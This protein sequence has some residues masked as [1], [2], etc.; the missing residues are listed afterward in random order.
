MGEAI[1]FLATVSKVQMLSDGGLR[2]TFDAPETA[3]LQAAELM[4]CK[5]FEQVLRVVCRAQRTTPVPSGDELD[6]E[7]SFDDE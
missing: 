2:F 6:A 7:Y 3:I 4:T 1:E 5:R